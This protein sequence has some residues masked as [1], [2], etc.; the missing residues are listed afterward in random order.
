MAMTTD[1]TEPTLSVIIPHYNDPA[2]LSLCL[3]TLAG[4]RL[5]G[6]EI[7]VVDNG[8]SVPLDTVRAAHP[9]VRFLSEPAQGAAHARNTGVAASRGEILAF[10]DA[11]CVPAA[12]WVTVARAVVARADVVGGEVTVFDETP[13]PRSG[14]EAFEAVFAFDTRAYVDK[15]DLAV[16]ANLVTTRAVFDAVG[17]FVDGVSEDAEWSA[18]ARAKGFSLAHADELRVKHPSRQDWPA[19]V[20]KWRRIT[21]ESYALA[22]QGPGQPRLSWALKASMMPLSVVAHLPKILRSPDLTDAGERTRAIGT[23]LRL[24]LARMRWMLRLLAGGDI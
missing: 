19:L 23:L 1:I 10:L 7:V 18:R 13:G 12:D 5:D 15:K 20:R 21:R 16:T 24:R 14:A 11:D 9:G 4:N 6:V 2:R 8:S 3:D 22:M 17:P